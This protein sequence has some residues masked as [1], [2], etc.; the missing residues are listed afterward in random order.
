VLTIFRRKNDVGRLSSTTLLVKGFLRTT[1]SHS[2]AAVSDANS[3]ITSSHSASA[4]SFRFFVSSKYDINLSSMA[5]SADIYSVFL[6]INSVVELQS[7]TSD[8]AVL[9]KTL[10][11][12][13][14]STSF[15][16]KARIKEE[17]LSGIRGLEA[18]MVRTFR[19]LGMLKVGMLGMI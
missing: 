15:I 9:A 13:G 10:R 5:R 18:M 4:R 12:E 19:W 3:F 11:Y 1:N 16:F 2:L 17:Y 6:S 14:I 7:E 8:K